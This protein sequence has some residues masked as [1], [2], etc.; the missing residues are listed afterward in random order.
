M[1]A[2][3]KTDV[4][5]TTSSTDDQARRVTLQT[6]ALAAVAQGVVRPSADQGPEIQFLRN[7]LS[8]AG[9]DVFDSSEGRR[10]WLDTLQ[11][12]LTKP[13]S[14][15]AEL[16]E[17]AEILRLTLVETM[18]VALSVAVEEEV[19]IGRVLAYLQAP[20]GGSRPT[21][22]LLATTLAGLAPP[23]LTAGDLLVNGAGAR[24]RL[25][26]LL[27]DGPLPERVVSVPLH[28]CLA[29]RGRDGVWPGATIGTYEGADVALPPS[30]SGQAE[31]QAAGLVASPDQVLVI[32]T[33]SKSE[34][35]SVA[36]S[37]AR[38]ANSRALF[39][40]SDKTDALG[41]WLLMRR[42]LPVFCFELG[43]GERKALPAIPSYRGPVLALCG[44]DG[45]VEA[46]AGTALNWTIPVPPVG[47]RKRLWRMAIGDDE[48]AEDLA[49]NHRHGCGRIAQLGRLAQHQCRVKGRE[50]PAMEDIVAA[51]W[52][53]EGTGIESLAQPLRHAIPDEALV[54]TPSLR[55]DLN[56]LL[57][58]CR[59]RDSLV[60]GLGISCV[61]RYHPGVCA[62][63]VGV[64]GTGKTLAA[65][66]L[67]TR[68]GLPLYRV[69]LASV[70]SKYIG[71]TE[72]NLAQLLARA[73]QAEVVLLFDE[74]DSLFGKRTEVKEANDRF[75]N[76]QTNYLLQRIE[77]FDGIT[78]LT[79]NS[80]T[81]FDSA[82]S[83]RIDAIVEFPPPGPEERRLLWQSHLG[84]SHRLTMREMNQLAAT[85]DLCGGHIRN[86]VLTAAVAAQ[87]Q[88]RAI[89]Y[90]DVIEGLGG[91]YRKL[92]RQVPSELRPSK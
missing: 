17:L 77:S 6:Y 46:P 8:A 24:S 87:E 20:L 11:Q 13:N 75:A 49:R 1:E 68:L 22:G 25:I 9:L 52:A 54:T 15:D 76:A 84:E 60:E 61:A 67:A 42:L 53:G 30:V 90:A 7:R 51:S 5:E 18:A 71:E 27:G 78:L 36:E 74:A 35:R 79:S 92:G 3:A 28:L 50:Q 85:A 41:A 48:I 55:K 82:F 62:L 83:R 38:F 91:E 59:S 88:D 64:S 80:K 34:G 31:R 16:M 57:L 56:S 70:T 33:G 81:R 66:W 39:L 73:E 29:L 44:P 45:S 40:E 2:R 26:T 14:E 63:F 19:M 23:G 21:V 58:R 10:G 43:P 89:E 72:K 12:T 65:G 47:E 69:D 37:I 32:R 4:R 86:I